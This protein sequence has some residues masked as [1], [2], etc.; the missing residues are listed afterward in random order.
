MR[1]FDVGLRI[2]AAYAVYRT[3]AAEVMAEWL[4]LSYRTGNGS[5]ANSNGG[6]VQA[7][8]AWGKTRPY[9]RFDRLAIDPLSPFIGGI[10]SSRTHTVGRAH[11]S[12]DVDRAEGAVRALG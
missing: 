9:Y 6:Y 8:R 12:G 1:R 4:R 3:P 5:P 2:P 7:S 11:R 10:E